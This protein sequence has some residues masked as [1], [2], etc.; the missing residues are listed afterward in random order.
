METVHS[1]PTIEQCWSFF[2]IRSENTGLSN[3]KSFLTGHSHIKAEML[4]VL[5]LL[6]SLKFQQPLLTFL[7][8]LNMVHQVYH[9]PTHTI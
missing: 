1:D 6:K 4:T 2:R 7:L 3:S 9:I 8:S 5:Y